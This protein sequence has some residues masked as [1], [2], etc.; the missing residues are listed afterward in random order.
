MIMYLIYIYLTA[1]PIRL[2]T[3][4]RMIETYLI[5]NI[6]LKQKAKKTYNEI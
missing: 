3:Y 1:L 2:T 4:C 6:T 5:L